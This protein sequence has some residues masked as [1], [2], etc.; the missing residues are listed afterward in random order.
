MPYKSIVT[1]TRD[2]TRD[3]GVI[4]T[5]LGLAESEGG[6]LSAVCLGIDRIQ[7]GAYYAGANAIA[8]Q[9]SM[10]EAQSEANAAEQDARDALKGASATWDTTALAVQ[11]GTLG[12]VV[13]SRAE[14]A[15][16]VVLPKPYGEGRGQEDVAILESALFGTRAPV[17]VVPL[18]QRDRLATDR[19]MIGWNQSAEALAAVRAALPLLVRAKAVDIA[20]IDP[21]AHGPDRSDPGGL[22]AEMLARHGVRADISVLA[23]TMPRVSDVMCRHAGDIEADLIVMGAY[24]H[25]RLREAILGG[26]TRNMLEASAVP[27]F[28]AH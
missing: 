25:S 6:H 10:D 21:P 18:G 17:L 9:Q 24:G 14:F 20:I 27:V 16:L 4:D 19:I 26:A 11:L 5:A 23:R 3:R 1:F 2:V 28:M 22:L 8:L 15:D 13:A 12:H 7:P